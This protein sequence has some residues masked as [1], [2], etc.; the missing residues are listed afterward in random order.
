MLTSST[1]GVAADADAA[2][3]GD[4]GW[5][6]ASPNAQGARRTGRPDGLLTIGLANPNRV[7]PHSWRRRLLAA[8]GLR[9]SI[10]GSCF[11]RVHEFQ[12]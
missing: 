1:R 7:R 10:D 11:E 2:R 9:A 4:E 12:K 8:V 5:A 6:R 3:R